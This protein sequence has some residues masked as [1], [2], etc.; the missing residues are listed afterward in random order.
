M[1]SAGTTRD[2]AG[3]REAVRGRSERGFEALGQRAAQF[4]AGIA[5][6]G[7]DMAHPWTQPADQGQQEGRNRIRIQ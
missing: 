5:P 1:S 2:Q 7:E 3:L 6:I 4:V